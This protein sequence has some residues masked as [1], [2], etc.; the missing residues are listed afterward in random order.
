[1]LRSIHNPLCLAVCLL[2]AAAG[3]EAGTLSI[4][5]H[6]RWVAVSHIY[7]GDTFRTDKGEKVRLL[8]I[9]TP[10]MPYNDQPGQILAEQAKQR[11]TEL[12][13][14]KL[15]RLS[16]D[17]EKRD[18]YGRTLAQIYLRNGT[19]INAQMVG[20]GLA[21]VY[22]FAPDFRWVSELQQAE[23]VARDK[24]LGIW[25]TERFRVLDGKS[26]SK[27]LAGQ[28]RV[29]KGTVSAARA[30]GFRIDKLAV[31]VPR[32]YRR[33]FKN[34]AIAHNEEQV[35]IRGTLRLAGNGQLYMALHSPADL[36]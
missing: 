21:F 7:D 31:S 30:W 17:A 22:T 33:W 25:N 19:W 16:M 23:R 35:I 18:S 14:G 34:E 10:E 9:N 5:D 20:E 4:I 29:L 6:S 24:Q 26:V 13:S 27:R 2:L 8:G 1:M 36:E 3:A 12:I 11:L 15:V 28:F 32:K